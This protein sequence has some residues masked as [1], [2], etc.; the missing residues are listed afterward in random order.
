LIFRG[1]TESKENDKIGDLVDGFRTRI[2]AIC[3]P[4]VDQQYGKAK[5]H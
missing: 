5:S 1:P 3:R 4:I 2:E